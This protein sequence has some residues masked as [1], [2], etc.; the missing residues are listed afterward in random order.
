MD[1][2]DNIVTEPAIAYGTS[3]VLMTQKPSKTLCGLVSLSKDFDY[4]KELSEVL[5]EKYKL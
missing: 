3:Q 4:K 2:K 1:N 5:A